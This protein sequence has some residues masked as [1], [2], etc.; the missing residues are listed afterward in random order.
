MT[1][2]QRKTETRIEKR[3]RAAGVPDAARW[4]QLRDTLNARASAEGLIDV[5]FER[6]DSPL[7]RLL[8]GATDKGLVRLALPNES[9]E[10]VLAELS[11]R[12]SSRL[13]RTTH[14]AVTRARQQLDEYFDRHRRGFDLA[15]DWRLITGFRHAVLEAT[16]RIPYGFTASYRQVA[17]QAGHAAATRAAGTALAGNPLP[18]VI[19]CHRVLPSTG[20]L[21]GYRG[22]VEA[23]QQLLEIEGVNISCAR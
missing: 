21:G 9:E 22:G 23:K 12:I 14:A 13:V 15:L 16:A 20:G 7:G 11:A 4:Q 5:A 19:P 1:N 10:E 8:L 18:I 17:A 6:H 3:L 2:T